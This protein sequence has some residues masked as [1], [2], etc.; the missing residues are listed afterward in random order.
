MAGPSHLEWSDERLGPGLAASLS[1]SSPARA[2]PTAGLTLRMWSPGQSETVSILELNKNHFRYFRTS[3]TARKDPVSGNTYYILINHSHIHSNIHYSSKFIFHS[4]V[5]L[6]F[7]KL[8]FQGGE[9]WSAQF[10]SRTP[11]YPGTWSVHGGGS[12]SVNFVETNITNNFYIYFYSLDRFK[13]Q[14][15]ASIQ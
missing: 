11:E 8:L 12:L 7:E 2:S 15:R 3:V 4:F 14:Y 9:N 13:S 1:R 5:Y 10:F 6:Q